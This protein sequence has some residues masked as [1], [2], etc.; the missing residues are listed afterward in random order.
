[1][2]PKRRI[3]TF[4]RM[5]GLP[6]LCSVAFVAEIFPVKHCGIHARYDSIP[7]YFQRNTTT[8]KPEAASIIAASTAPS[9]AMEDSSVNNDDDDTVDENGCKGKEFP[10]GIPLRRKGW[11]RVKEVTHEA[12]RAS[13]LV[14]L[15]E[16]EGRDPK[17]GALWPSSWV[18]AKDVS[19]SA[20]REWAAKKMKGNIM[21]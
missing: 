17:T 5:N 19:A 20:I 10:N 21:T 4:H 11:Y 1:M 9:H 2:A 12:R 3:K 7:A 18:A 16:W 6:Q 8:R 13:S 14:Y 15:V